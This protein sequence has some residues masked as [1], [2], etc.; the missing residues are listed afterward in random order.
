V[1]STRPPCDVLCHPASAGLNLLA[2]CVA[3]TLATMWFT[4]SYPRLALATLTNLLYLTD[5]RFSTCTNPSQPVSSTTIFPCKRGNPSTVTEPTGGIASMKTT[6]I[7]LTTLIAVFHLAAQDAG[8]MRKPGP[9]PERAKLSFLTGSFTTET[10]M[11]AGPMSPE[12]VVARGT[13]TLTYAVDSMFILLEDQS[14]NP[15]LGKYKAHGVLGY[16]ARDGKYT[17]AMYNNFGDAPQYKGVFSGDTLVLT[18]KV[19]YP[20]GSFDQKLAWYKEGTNVRLKVYN[21]M[22]QGPSLVVDQIS[23]PVPGDATK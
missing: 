12:E 18:S 6:T 22:G 4:S 15:V 21:D 23:A 1:L 3:A 9:G 2:G 8:T 14:D 20:G 11:P 7:A 13:S 5:L 19:E 17:L 10:H 16:N